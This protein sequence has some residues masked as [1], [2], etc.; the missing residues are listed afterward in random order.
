VTRQA[1]MIAY[2]DNFQFMMILLIA[3][4][5]MVLLMRPPRTTPGEQVHPVG[6]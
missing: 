2:L 3:F 6:E 1:A 4:L 5:P